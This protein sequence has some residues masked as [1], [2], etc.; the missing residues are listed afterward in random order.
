MI[1]RGFVVEHRVQLLIVHPDHPQRLV[2]DLLAFARHDR[3]RVPH[4]PH[5]VFE[6]I[7]VVGAWLG[8]ALA[9]LCKP[10][11]REV[12]GSE[13][14]GNPVEAPGSVGP[15]R[16]DPRERVRAAQHLDGQRA[17]R[18]EVIGID[19]LAGGEGACIQLG[20]SAVDCVH[21][22]PPFRKDITAASWE[23]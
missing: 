19:P 13:H 9:R 3:N 7:P 8:V 2:H 22:S 17:G 14:T 12:V 6:D 11:F 18:D 1:Q 16:H 23:V 15:D 21:R 4:I 10:D 20:D 5:E